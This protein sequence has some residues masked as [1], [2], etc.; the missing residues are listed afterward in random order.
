MTEPDL[1]LENDGKT[2]TITFAT[3]PP[4]T[5]ELDVP[6]LEALLEKL[7]EFRALMRPEVS[8]TFPEGQSFPA[9]GDP[10]WRTKPDF[11]HGNVFLHIRDPRFGWLRNIISREEARNLAT[12]L[13]GDTEITP[14]VSDAE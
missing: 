14:L 11:L 7:G 10:P 9:I 6:A 4:A 2:L 8:W 1:K 5:L 13:Q 3:T 12:A